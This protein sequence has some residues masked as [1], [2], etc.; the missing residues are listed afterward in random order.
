MEAEEELRYQ[1]DLPWLPEW[2][3]GEEFK[4]DIL[5]M[6]QGRPRRVVGTLRRIREKEGFDRTTF[7]VEEWTAIRRFYSEF[8]RTSLYREILDHFSPYDAA[9]WFISLLTA[10]AELAGGGRDTP[11][12]LADAL[13][14]LAKEA[15][16]LFIPFL[17]GGKAAGKGHYSIKYLKKTLAI[18]EALKKLVVKYKGASE[19][20]SEKVETFEPSSDLEPTPITSICD[21]TH[22]FPSQFCLPDELFD[23]K[24]VGRQLLKPQWFEVRKHPRKYVMLLDVSGSM[25]GEKA[26]YAAASAIA[27]IQNAMRSGVNKAV[28]VP[29]DEAP[30]KP[31]EGKGEACIRK[32]LDLPFSG[33]GTDIDRALEFADSLHPDEIILITDGED[34]V[35][36][37]PS[38]KL[39]TVFCG[40]GNEALREISYGYEEVEP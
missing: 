3:D 16:G 1:G 6:F 15:S 14:L 36:Y 4:N 27:L 26:I 40:G 35:S 7:S 24:L 38:A 5:A 32:L 33:G 28:V 12:G 2:Y 19:V 8:P 25:K 17:V 21:V 13:S 23:Y 29:F 22:I 34:R 18:Q 9:R 39:Y 37:R 31:I 30:H 10:K 11:T 20:S